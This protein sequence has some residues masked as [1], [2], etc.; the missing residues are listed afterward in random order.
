MEKAKDQVLSILVWAIFIHILYVLQHL[1]GLNWLA[2][3]IGDLK[4]FDTST[5]AL[6]NLLYARTLIEILLSR[7]HQR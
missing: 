6:N 2:S 3:L 4:C 5:E 7:C 1:I